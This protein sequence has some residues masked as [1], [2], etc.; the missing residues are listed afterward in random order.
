MGSQ[1]FD[2]N[3]PNIAAVDATHTNGFGGPAAII[4]R[5]DGRGVLGV[6]GPGQCAGHER[7]LLPAHDARDTRLEHRRARL[8]RKRANPLS[9]FDVPAFG[10]R[11]GRY[12]AALRLVDQPGRPQPDLN[13]TDRRVIQRQRQ[14][15]RLLL[16]DRRAL[17]G[18]QTDAVP[19]ALGG[20]ECGEQD[21]DDGGRRDC[22]MT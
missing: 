20:A 12:D 13:G 6:S 17:L 7:R 22:R 11:Q 1:A 14:F 4:G 2:S 5:S 19:D 21:Q 9:D 10:G 3:D 18:C 8:G 15:V 16:R